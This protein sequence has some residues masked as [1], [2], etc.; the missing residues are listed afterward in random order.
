V[1][2]EGAELNAAGSVRAPLLLGGTIVLASWLAVLWRLP[3]MG[4]DIRDLAMLSVAAGIIV[5]SLFYAEAFR[6]APPVLEV[7]LGMI[8]GWLGAEAT[9]SL[10]ALA[11]MGGSSVMFLA[12]L[13]VDTGLLRSFLAESILVGLTSFLAPALIS[14][15]VVAAMGQPLIQALLVSIGVSTTSVAV[16]YSIIKTSGYYKTRI[17]QVA[18]ASAMAADVASII[19][20]MAV[21]SRPSLTLAAYIVSIFV[22]PIVARYLLLW[23]PSLSHEAEVRI[24]IALLLA[25]TLISEAVGVHGVLAS[26]ILGLALQ[27]FVERP[28]VRGK[29]EG[30]INGFLAPVFFVVAGLEAAYSNPASIVL[31]ALGLLAL[32]FPVKIG[33][34]HL[35]FARIAGFTARPITFSFGARLT[36]STLIAYMGVKTGLL[37]PV[38]SGAIM[39]SAALATLLAGLA[40]RAPS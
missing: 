37:D 33:A 39:L 21:A 40:T 13:E 35:A 18:L 20:F 24:I 1:V 14:L 16:V 4:G 7:L 36:V 5:S 26:F 19:A 34:T 28:E 31:P 23:L 29:V 9:G 27:D 38:M 15:I 8:A 25:V 12:G 2:L 22:G 10:E 30:V 11:V 17:G 3:H 6:I 32:S